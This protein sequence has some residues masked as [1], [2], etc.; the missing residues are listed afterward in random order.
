L[1]TPTRTIHP[2]PFKHLE[3]KRFED[4]VRQLI[5]D[6]RPW[7]QLE[8]TGRAGSDD[9]FDARG[10]EIVDFSVTDDDSDDGDDVT[11]PPPIDRLWLIQCKRE[12]EIGPTKL[13]DHLNSIT[14]ES[15]QG[16]HGLI[17]AAPCD[18]SKRAHDEF[19]AWCADKGIQ[20]LYLWGEATIEDFLYQP[21]N[22]H[23][24]FAYFGISLQI[25][26]QKASAAIRRT[27]SLKRKLRRLI[28]EDDVETP[29][30]L[31]DITYDRYPNCPG[32]SLAESRCL[33]IRVMQW[34]SGYAAC[35]FS[36]VSILR[37]TVM[38]INNGTLPLA[39]I[40]PFH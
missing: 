21:K 27:V 13:V 15:F 23:L 12:K 37:I 6:F 32:Q 24:L 4:L 3:P 36:Y 38:N 22:D 30:V 39:S 33:G 7:R 9:G 11:P 14:A 40:N 25:R 29:V 26:R 16:L 2:L 28:P 19:R 34:E 18:F 1:A 8:P 20:E 5:Y 10:F 31:R 35:I 17:F